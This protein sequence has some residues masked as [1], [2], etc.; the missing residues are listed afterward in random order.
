MVG[1]TVPNRRGGMS[2]R[3]LWYPRGCSCT[4]TGSSSCPPVTSCIRLG[5]SN[6]WPG[7]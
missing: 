4:R 5:S 2:S 6:A 3:V 7:C 1:V